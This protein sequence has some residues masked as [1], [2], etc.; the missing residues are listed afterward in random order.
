MKKAQQTEQELQLVF[1]IIWDEFIKQLHL[2][3]SS[4]LSV[5]R[6][7]EQA[8]YSFVESYKGYCG[9]LKEKN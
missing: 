4:N 7:V 8:L 5:T 3:T 1:A 9:Q 2:N 6:E